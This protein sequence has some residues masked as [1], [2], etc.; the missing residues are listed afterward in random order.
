MGAFVSGSPGE[1]IQ[2]E[3]ISVCPLAGYRPC[4]SPTAVFK[5]PVSSWICAALLKCETHDLLDLPAYAAGRWQRWG[6]GEIDVQVFRVNDDSVG[7]EE[8]SSPP[9]VAVGIHVCLLGRRGVWGKE[10]PSQRDPCV[11][12]V[13]NSTH[14]PDGL[15][16]SWKG[17]HPPT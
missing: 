1:K 2:R 13:K 8:A 15:I 17:V 6:R 7:Q 14:S 11:D 4:R 12:D 5:T 3:G 10:M 16:F 9:A